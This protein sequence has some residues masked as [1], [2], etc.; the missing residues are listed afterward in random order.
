M[1]SRTTHRRAHTHTHTHHTHTRARARARAR[2]SPIR[3]YQG[4]RSEILILNSEMQKTERIFLYF[5]FLNATKNEQSR[6]SW[7]SSRS[8]GYDLR[9]SFSLKAMPHHI[10]CVSILSHLITSPHESARFGS[11]KAGDTIPP[12]STASLPHQS[13]AGPVPCRDVTFNDIINKLYFRR[14]ESHK[15]GA[16]LARWQ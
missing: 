4:S 11:S 1:H 14:Y 10:L 7:R 15:V 9:V 16:K 13:L 12:P 2:Y 6:A 5:I 8:S 3:L